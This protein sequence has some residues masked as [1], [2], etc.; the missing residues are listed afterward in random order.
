MSILGFDAMRAVQELVRSIPA[1][2]AVRVFKYQ[3]PPAAQLRI[4]RNDVENRLFEK[5]LRLRENYQLPFW[6]S[7]LLSCFSCDQ[8]PYSILNAAQLHVSHR[9]SEMEVQRSNVLDGALHRLAADLER[10]S[11]L[12]IVSEA[13]TINGMNE[14]IPLL[15]FHIPH[16]ETNQNIVITILNSLLPSGFILLRS[17]RSYHAWGTKTITS[18]DYTVFLARAM[19]YSPII[20]RAYLAHQL[21][22]NRSA[23]RISEGYPDKP[24]PSV[25]FTVGF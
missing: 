22:E 2:S 24:I 18:K 13:C 6:D 17:G 14:H 25:I 1:I 16:S 8:V 11:S 15:D 20:D 10:D 12:A 3:P 5:A 4:E 19:L 9:S 7:L 21:I 23:L